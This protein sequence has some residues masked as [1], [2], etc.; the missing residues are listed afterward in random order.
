MREIAFDTETTG[1]DPAQGHRIVEIGCVEMVDKIR[2]GETFH[3]YIN[4]QRDVP[5]EASR[6]H[7]LTTEKLADKPIF[8][9]IVEEFLAFIGESTL[10][11]HNA[12][13]DMKFID[14]ELKNHGYKAIG[15]SRAVDTLALTR[16]AFPGAPA[17]LD[18]L[19]RRFAIDS[20]ART[21]HGALLDAELLADVYLELCGGRQASIVLED[22]ADESETNILQQPVTIPYR[23]FPPSVEELE[24]NQVFVS[25]I[26][27]SLWNAG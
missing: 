25:T 17:S 27:N 6:I 23:Q 24:A 5:E 12:S 26:K 13:F 2:T 22:A 14:A 9:Q 16:R 3:V 7:G 18:A 4:P 19:C 11:A 21:Y 15:M 1:L 20:S 10:V 8:S